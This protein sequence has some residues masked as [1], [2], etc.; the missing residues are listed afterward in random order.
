MGRERSRPREYL[1]L[2]IAGVIMIISGAG[3]TAVREMRSK[4][5]GRE[6]LIAAQD[7]LVQRDFTGSLRANQR[8]LSLYD[9]IPVADEALFH[10]AMIYAHPGY[11]KKDYKR[12]LDLFKRLVGAFPQSRFACPA[13]IWIEVLQENERCRKEVEESNRSVKENNQENQRL[14]LEI[15]ELSNTIHKSK[16]I[17]IEIDEKRK[18]LSK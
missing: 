1:Y 15:E 17:D 4:W 14:R 18:R 12:S 5:Q 3:C 7:L 8:A 10:T 13:S 2:L 6:H 16:Q 9:H 11:P